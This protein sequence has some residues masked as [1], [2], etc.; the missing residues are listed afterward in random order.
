MSDKKYD[1]LNEK[2]LSLISGGSLNED[3]LKVLDSFVPFYLESFPECTLDDFLNIF[4]KSY[5]EFDL[6]SSDEETIAEIREY[7]AHYWD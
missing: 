1:E 3:Q 6:E 7:I 2:I 4:R 5:P